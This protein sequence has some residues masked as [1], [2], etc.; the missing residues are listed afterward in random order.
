MRF[1]LRFTDLPSLPQALRTTV[2]VVLV[3]AL[4]T[5]VNL[6][7]SN[8]FRDGVEAVA[9]LG[10]W[11]ADEVELRRG[12]YGHRLFYAILEVDVT[13]PTATGRA[14]VSATFSK[15]PV[16]G[17]QL[18]GYQSGVPLRPGGRGARP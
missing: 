11:N 7:S 6:F 1:E 17:W 14:P 15:L 3:C 4:A 16:F 13:V 8:P 5:T 12:M 18:T 2:L 10:G 9:N